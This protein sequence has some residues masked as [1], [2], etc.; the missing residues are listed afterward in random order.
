MTRARF[1]A[2]FEPLRNQFDAVR[3]NVICAKRDL[4]ALKT[5]ILAM[6]D[7]LK[8]AHVVK[9]GLFDVKHSA[10]GMLDAEFAVQYLVLAY[11]AAHAS[12]QD[13]MGNIALL[14]RAES[15]GLLPAGVGEAAAQAYR[16]LRHVQH[17][18]RLDEA[19]TQ[20]PESELQIERQ[21]MSKL[22]EHVFS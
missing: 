5:E 16:Q 2:G 7:R 1:V 15:V 20:L 10:G 12:L 11:S 3:K 14:Q 19:T 8:S 9:T 18:A 4:L 21:A 22:W 13:N 6:R 17:M